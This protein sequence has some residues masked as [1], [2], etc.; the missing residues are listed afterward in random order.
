MK[1]PIKLRYKKFKIHPTLV[2][3]HS[4]MYIPH[5]D[6]EWIYSKI[7]GRGGAFNNYGKYSCARICYISTVPKI[8]IFYYNIILW[9]K[10]VKR[11]I[12]KVY[13]GGFYHEW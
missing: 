6:S 8:G 2:P 9:L 12:K 5:I 1:N 13:R 10:Y 3:T 7:K 4:C 11:N